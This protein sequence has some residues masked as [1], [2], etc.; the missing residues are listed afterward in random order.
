MAR[1][2]VRL[3]QMVVQTTG[4]EQVGAGVAAVERIAHHD[5]LLQT[6]RFLHVG[7]LLGASPIAHSCSDP[8]RVRFA[9]SLQCPGFASSHLDIFVNAKEEKI[10]CCACK[11]HQA[12]GALKVNEQQYVDLGLRECPLECSSEAKG[13]MQFVRGVHSPDEN[14]WRGRRHLSIA[15]KSVHPASEVSFDLGFGDVVVPETSAPSRVTET[16]TT[17]TRSCLS[18]KVVREK[19]LKTHLEQV[20][21]A[22]RRR[23]VPIKWVGV[24]LEAQRLQRSRHGVITP[25]ADKLA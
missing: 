7:L 3:S 11:L 1:S 12:A 23:P 10:V 22:L 4:A 24:L 17:T 20:N 16:P 18:S 21:N 19:I 9:L 13:G 6:V 5:Q 15:K 8:L 25:Q 14:T 2:R